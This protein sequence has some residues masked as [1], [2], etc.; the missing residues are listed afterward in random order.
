[1]LLN[2]LLHSWIN[3]FQPQ[4]RYLFGLLILIALALGSGRARI[5]RRPLGV[6]LIAAFLLSLGSFVFVALPALSSL[7]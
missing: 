2:S 1:V 7:P 6:I 4:G 3:D 5:D